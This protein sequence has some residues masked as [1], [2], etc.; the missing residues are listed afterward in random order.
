MTTSHVRSGGRRPGLWRW[1]CSALAVAAVAWAQGPEPVYEHRVV[2]ATTSLDRER[3]VEDSLTR[4]VNQLAALGFE[5]GAMMGGRGAVLDR[6][7]ERK[8][9]VAGQVDHG[10]QVFVVMHR[11]VDRPVA[12]REYRFLHTRGPLGVEEIVAAYGRDGFRLTAT[13]W[14]GDTFHGAFER[15]AG[16]APVDY[17]VFRTARRQGWDAQMLADGDVKQRLRRVVPLTLD[18]ALVEL[19]PPAASPAEF[20]WESDAPHQR[21]RLE[22]RLNARAAAG[23]R[24]QLARLRG[25]V[26]DVALLKPAGSPGPG[27]AL[28]LDDG[29]WGAPCGRGSIA[30]AD[31]RADGDVYCVAEDPKGPVTNRGFDVVVAAE[32]SLGNQPFFGRLGCAV[33]ARLGAN[34]AAARRV[35]RAVQLEEEIGRRLERG[36]RVTRAFAG[37]KEDG[38]Q[39]LVFFTSRLPLP[40]ATGKPAPRGKAPRLS[41]EPD[42]LGQQL[43][44]GRER[45]INEALA[46]EL[47]DLKLDVWAEIHDV[48]A[49]QHVL[50]LGCADSR[51]DRE[52]AETV[53]R[54]LLVRSPYANFRVRNEIIVDLFR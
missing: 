34:R 40:A 19:G 3:D 30:G 44:A 52:R 45:E 31:I 26:L 33:R 5:V 16:Q 43:L 8:A 1:V 36:Y 29:P 4:N 32:A 12:A 25:N 38:E 14:E 20:A 51:P 18:S 15:A 37:V 24:V 54:R 9:Y 42:G 7:L 17:R 21:S 39:R 10:G 53:L 49:S 50:L 28:D 46:A 2:V 48:R 11:P 47:R 6:L 35:A 22:T 27:P 41:A 13:A 23:F